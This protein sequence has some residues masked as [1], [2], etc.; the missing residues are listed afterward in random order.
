VTKREGA[1]VIGFCPFATVRNIPPGANDPA[2]VPRLAILHVDAGNAESLFDFFNGPSGGVESHIFVKKTGEIEQ[3]RSIYFQAD[4]NLDA[5]DFAVSIETQG[6]GAGEWNAAQLASIKRLL[7]W[8]HTEAG[9]PLRK[10]QHWDGS[11]VGYHVM[12]GAP[13][14]WTPLAKTCPGPDRVAQFNAVIVPWLAAQTEPKPSLVIGTA[15]LHNNATGIDVMVAAGCDSIG[16]SEANLVTAELEAVDKYRLLYGRGYA[17]GER[18]AREVPILT[19]WKYPT[20]AQQTIQAS[21]PVEPLR[22]APGRVI[23]V[24]GFDHPIGRV[25]HI[26]L[27]PNAAVSGLTVDVPRV[28]EYDESMHTLD[29]TI[30]YYRA[31]GFLTIVTGDLNF[32]RDG[33]SPEWLDPY[34]VFAKHGLV[35]QSH[36]IDAIAHPAELELAVP[37]TVI[38]ADDMGSDHPALIAELQPKEIP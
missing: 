16:F 24:S 13:S 9:I 31:E 38:S 10:V 36:R 29:R 20:L 8:L 30:R 3:Y 7:K 6:F 17:D 12:F 25:A 34:E 22:I 5:N 11:G 2:I 33:E 14:H 19:K 15:N 27:H 32:R 26:A 35:V 23:T 28:R 21:E 18:I 1:I 4:A 37:L